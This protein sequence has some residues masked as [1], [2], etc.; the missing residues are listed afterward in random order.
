[1]RI[2]SFDP[3]LTGWGYAVFDDDILTGYGMVSTKRGKTGVA[4]DRVN[5]SMYIAERLIPLVEPCDAIVSELP[6]GSQSSAAAVMIGIV[7]GLITGVAM[8]LGKPIFFYLQRDWSIYLHG[9]HTSDKSET[10][11]K[12][13]SIYEVKGSKKEVE[14]ISDAISVFLYHRH[15]LSER[16]AGVL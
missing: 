12:I 7:I 5:R 10:V 8:S 16:T 4:W 1:M 3:S 2:I 11:R 14:A 15:R 6:H 13:L 9:R